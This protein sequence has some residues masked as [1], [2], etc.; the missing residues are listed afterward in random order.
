M[1]KLKGKVAIVTGAGSGIGASIARLFAKNGAKVLLTDVD[2]ENGKKVT[3]EI[4]SNGG[5]AAFYKA[6]VSKAEDSE[7]SVAK[8]VEQFGGLH[9]AVNNAGISGE[10]KPI[11]EIDLDDWHKVLNI[12]LNGV[13]YGLRYQIPQ[14][15]KGGSG[16]I[17]NIASILGQVGF[18]GSAAYVT[19]KHGVVGLTQNAGIEYGAEGV[20]VNAVGPGFV[21]TPLL[22]A[23]LDEE[24]T[25]MLEGMH[26]IGRM[27]RPDEIAQLVLWL[28][29]DDASF[30]NATYYPLDGG[31]LAQ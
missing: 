28:A 5:E 11:G 4:K 7:S 17:I 1:E 25:K 16:S 26:P 19:A 24:T 23:N 18:K 13:F 8:A 27:G 2:E 30:A 14:M 15:V 31:Y 9:I 21:K 10:A 20:R 6:D 29:S 22:E 12:N 3:E